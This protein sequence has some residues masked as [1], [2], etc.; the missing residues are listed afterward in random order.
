M[1]YN[2]RRN[3]TTTGRKTSRTTRSGAGG[4]FSKQSLFNESSIGSNTVVP[5]KEGRALRQKTSNTDISESTER[6]A[7]DS[8]R[9]GTLGGSA[10]S[11]GIT[12]FVRSS[13]SRRV[14]KDEVFYWVHENHIDTV[15]SHE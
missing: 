6:H 13:T 7:S 8:R 14:S 2:T 5:I 11:S 10:T 1:P 4:G 9:T 12:S 15:D 3:K